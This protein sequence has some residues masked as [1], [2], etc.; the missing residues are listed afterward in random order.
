M[1]RVLSNMHCSDARCWARRKVKASKLQL[2]LDFRTVC[3]L[4]QNT[5]STPP[6]HSTPILCIIKSLLCIFLHLYLDVTLVI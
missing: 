4:K 6:L 1:L 3:A 2:S 5:G